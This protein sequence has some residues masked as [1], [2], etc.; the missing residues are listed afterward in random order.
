MFSSNLRP[1]TISLCVFIAFLLAIQGCASSSIPPSSPDW[2]I[3]IIDSGREPIVLISQ[4]DTLVPEEDVANLSYALAPLIRRDLFCVQRLSV[5]PTADTK[6]PIKSYFLK[7]AGL[8]KQA[9]AHGADIITV[10]ILKGDSEKIKI[11]FEAYD[12]E[13]Q[14]LLLK[15]EME[16]KTSR[17]LQLEK[18]LVNQFINA[19]GM[20]LSEEEQRRLLSNNPKKVEAAIEY[21]RGLREAKKKSYTEALIAFEEASE[22]NTPL[23]LMFPEEAKVFERYNSPE[24][25]L[26]SLERAVA[27]D[28]NYAEAW[29]QL[30]I[31]AANYNKNA[32]LAMEYCY[33]ALEIA[34]RFGKARLSLGVRLYALGNVEGAIEQTKMAAE[35]L[36]MDPIPRYNLGIF[37]RDLKK[38]KL[39][40]AWFERAL[41]VNPGFEMARIELMNLSEK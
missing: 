13:N 6:V 5:V 3:S 10:G 33:R 25:A 11:E 7:K 32:D 31:H 14:N 17:I 9:K 34:P 18:E 2:E 26:S 21:G 20:I 30:N 40:R 24:R 35:L 19:L 37:F 39:A 41:E 8:K 27:I 36:P 4:F 16:D 22:L 28:E 29:Y 12:V 1:I 23:A 38:F 15:T